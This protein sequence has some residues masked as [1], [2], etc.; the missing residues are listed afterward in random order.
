VA[1]VWKGQSSCQWFAK[2]IV[3]GYAIRNITVKTTN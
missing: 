3:T 2:F 1:C